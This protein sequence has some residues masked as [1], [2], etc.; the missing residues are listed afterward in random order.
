MK[1]QNETKGRRIQCPHYSPLSVLDKHCRHY[2]D[3]GSCRRPGELQCVEWLRSN[4]YPTPPPDPLATDLLGHPVPQSAHKPTRAPT[5]PSAHQPG[6]P[7]PRTGKSAH[8]G[9]RQTTRP[10]SRQ[11]A[12]PPLGGFAPEDIE[13]FKKRGV[14][15]HFTGPLGDF[16]LVP[17]YRN[18]TR[19]ELTPEHLFLVCRVLQAFPGAAVTA[20]ENLSR[21]KTK[22]GEER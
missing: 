2:I 6:Q 20:F 12:L 17:E 5:A 19:R 7:S 14:E 3:G 1:P 11:N 15:I 18:N 4:G 22:E 13:S 8:E 10:V 21:E 9:T 16:W